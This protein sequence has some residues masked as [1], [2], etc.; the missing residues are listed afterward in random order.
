MAVDQIM[1]LVAGGAAAYAVGCFSTAYYLVL[2]L[3]GGDIRTLE[4]GTAGAR[5][6]AR[7]LGP[8]AGVAVALADIV[9]GAAAVWAGTLVAGNP[10]LS[11]LLAA[12]AIAGHVWPA[13]LGF[14]GGKGLATGFGALLWLYPAA[15][16][17][18]VA[19]NVCLSLLSRSV[20]MGTLAA[21]ASIPV[22][23]YAT[24][25]GLRPALLLAIPCAVV[26]F[27]H[28]GNIRAAF[29]RRFGETGP[30]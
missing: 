18:A 2:L 17:A 3:H 29:A 24:G 10:Q 1:W 4:T 7:V 11:P 9:K 6:A 21:T 25:V 12:S 15:A 16:A 13:Q 19:V 28:R 23:A 20:T 5:N 22:L 26:I 30:P 8:K 14:R 27:A